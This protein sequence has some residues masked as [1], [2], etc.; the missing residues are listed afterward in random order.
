MHDAAM[1]NYVECDCGWGGTVHQKAY[2]DGKRLMADADDKKNEWIEDFVTTHL[3]GNAFNTAFNTTTQHRRQHKHKQAEIIS[4]LTDSGYP[5]R[6]GHRVAVT[7]GRYQIEC[8]ITPALQSRFKTNQF[9][10]FAT[11]DITS[12]TLKIKH[13]FDDVYILVHDC[14]FII[15]P[16]EH[17]S[18]EHPLK[19]IHYKIKRNEIK[20]IMNSHIIKIAM[21]KYQTG[22]TPSISEGSPISTASTHHH[23]QSHTGIYDWGS[24]TISEDEAAREEDDPTDVLN[25]DMLV[26]NLCDWLAK[27]F[28]PNKEGVHDAI[29]EP[30]SHKHAMIEHKTN[31]A[32]TYETDDITNT[33]F[34]SALADA[35]KQYKSGI[36]NDGLAYARTSVMCR[37][38]HRDIAYTSS[39]LNAISLEV[40][41]SDYEHFWTIPGRTY[42]LDTNHHDENCRYIQGAV[43]KREK[44]CDKDV[45]YQC[46]GLTDPT[47][48]ATNIQIGQILWPKQNICLHIN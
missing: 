6:C 23:P 25:N 26:G 15:T 46:T 43:Y 38:C 13:K 33:E 22:G 39:D 48:S 2:V 8:H 27:I 36:T 28:P 5:T 4:I 40:S 20:S 14:G 30:H 41:M 45:S 3:S 18:A 21:L 11:I 17:P 42:A 44:C 34:I 37:T 31:D 32:D 10:P 7:D 1:E 24:T 9:R 47:G 35:E 19:Q 16:N 29:K 12:L